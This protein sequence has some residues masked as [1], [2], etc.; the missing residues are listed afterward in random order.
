VHLKRGSITF[1]QGKSK[2]AIEIPIHPEF[3]RWLESSAQPK[4][5]KAGVVFPGLQGGGSRGRN[6][7]ANQ[8]SKL[9]VKAQIETKIVK[10]KGKEGPDRTSQTFHSLRHSF[11][12]AMDNAGVS[13]EIQAAAHRPRLQGDRYTH[14]EL[15]ALRRAGD[16]I[17]GLDHQNGASGGPNIG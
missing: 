12:S 14:A 13:Q 3:K 17:L 5:P 9:V 10:A 11:N 4:K 8:F 7:L 6:G 1:T 16:A 15:E 2:R